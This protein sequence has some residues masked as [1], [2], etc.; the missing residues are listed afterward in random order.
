MAEDGPDVSP[1]PYCDWPREHPEAAQ[2]E[3]G[4]QGPKTSR[5]LDRLPDSQTG[6][7]ML[8][9]SQ[10]MNADEHG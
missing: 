2:L 3:A 9:M 4:E 8:L 7:R 6:L 5:G 1:T 10:P